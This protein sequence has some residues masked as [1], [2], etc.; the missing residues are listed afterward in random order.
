MSSSEAQRSPIH[1]A[2]ED[3][4]RE[5]S[6]PTARPEPAPGADDRR[7]SG[8]AGDEDLAA[9]AAEAR[10]RPDSAMGVAGNFERG[11][12][13]AGLDPETEPAT[14]AAAGRDADAANPNDPDESSFGGPL[15][16]SKHE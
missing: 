3:S 5:P 8:T 9:R 12:A 16:L 7:G 2:T 13:L 15:D 14:S 11:A 1:E 10:Q 6:G 4:S